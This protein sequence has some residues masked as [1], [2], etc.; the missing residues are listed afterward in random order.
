MQKINRRVVGVL[1]LTFAVASFGGACG[2]DNKKANVSDTTTTRAAS[3]FP[4][5]SAMARIKAAGTVKVGVKFDQPGFGLKNPTTGDVQGF[6]VEIAKRIAEAIDPAVKVEFVESISKNRETF[7]QNGTVDYVVAT[8]TIND[9]RK[10][11][12]DFAGPYFVA[13]QDI[14]VKKADTTVKSISDL[15]GKKV[16]SVTGSTSATNLAA[17]APQAQVTLFGKYSDCAQALTDGRV[18]AVTTD[19]TI[20]AGLVKDSAGAFKL[21]DAPFTDEPYG[22]GVKLGDDAFREFINSQ[23][24]AIYKNR[25]WAAAFK[26]TLG[27]LGLKTPTPPKVVRYKTGTTPAPTTTVPSTATTTA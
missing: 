3:A 16:C 20:L 24:E 13:R 10:Q 26:S 27:T 14:M 11:V 15:N 2:K 21:V 18:D 23:L 8:Y 5:G 12:V 1:A 9:T 22:I 19:N 4:A 6:D 25:D 17:K 7:I